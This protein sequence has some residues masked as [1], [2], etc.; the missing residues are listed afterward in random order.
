MARQ[1]ICDRCGNTAPDDNKSTNESWSTL[2]L[3]KL[4]QKASLYKEY[5]LCRTCT[6]AVRNL[7]A[8]IPTA[9]G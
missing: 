2:S 7:L 4:H 1:F 5:D 9:L 3:H 8:S 6:N